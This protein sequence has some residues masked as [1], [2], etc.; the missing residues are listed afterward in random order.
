MPLPRIPGGGGAVAILARGARGGEG[1]RGELRPPRFLHDPAAGCRRVV[2][3]PSLP[4]SRPDFDV[5]LGSARVRP[6]SVDGRA[7]FGGGGGGLDEVASHSGQ[8]PWLA[9]A[10]GP[11]L[12]HPLVRGWSRSLQ[13]LLERLLPMLLLL[14]QWLSV[15]PPLA[16]LSPRQSSQHDFCSCAGLFSAAS[17][18]AVPAVSSS[19]PGL[20]PFSLWRA[21]LRRQRAAPLSD[22]RPGAWH[23]A[24]PPLP[25]LPLRQ[26]AADLPR[27]AA[28]IPPHR[29]PLWLG[30]RLNDVFP[31]PKRAGGH[32]SSQRHRACH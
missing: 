29:C 24:A 13:F 20:P 11:W 23:P 18:V 17:A 25:P 16:R 8:P 12:A 19:L 2:D 21:S 22:L 15:W 26:R 7:Q 30:E 3:E 5:G 32:C 1:E 6:G 4:L 10:G 14:A 31:L 9:V 27:Q 28:S